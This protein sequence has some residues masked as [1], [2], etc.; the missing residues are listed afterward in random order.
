MVSLVDAATNAVAATFDYTPFGE[1]TA[2]EGDAIDRGNPTAICPFLFSTKYYDHEVGLNYFGY[3]YYNPTT[4]RWLNRDPLQEEGGLNL[5]GYC[6]NDPINLIDPIGDR[7]LIKQSSQAAFRKWYNRCI[8]LGNN[9]KFIFP[10][11]GEGAYVVKTLKWIPGISYIFG[12]QVVGFHY[13]SYFHELVP[14]GS[15]IDLERV[16]PAAEMLLAMV[17]DADNVY[18]FDN[19][20]WR[21]K[22]DNDDTNSFI[23]ADLAIGD[24]ATWAGNQI[25]NGLAWI[26]DIA[27]NN[28]GLLFALDMAALEAMR[29]GYPPEMFAGAIGEGAALTGRALKGLRTLRFI[30]SSSQFLSK[31]RGIAKFLARARPLLNRASLAIKSIRSVTVYRVE[32]PVRGNMRVIIGE[33]GEVAIVGKNNRLFLNFGSKARA[34]EF[35]AKRLAQ[36]S[37]GTQI[38]SF[39]V[40]RGFLEEIRRLAVPEHLS[41]QYPNRPIV[42][43][44][45]KAP[46]QYGL[47]P[48]LIQDLEMFI[49]QGT[50]KVHE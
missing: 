11:K 9:L 28:E 45:S 7:V 17:L 46:D 50:G 4:A 21:K 40:K 24:A 18:V 29:S 16:T 10:Q 36:G 8:K 35:L 34:E 43:D 22:T 5:Y 31:S 2:V 3:R 15:G 42:V 47:N 30:K 26:G 25:L 14:S 41:K 37:T 12:K 32:A 1:L 19:G 13:T 48:Q 27:E 23:R 20:G 39:K 38:K 6:Q 49:I 44:I 33:S